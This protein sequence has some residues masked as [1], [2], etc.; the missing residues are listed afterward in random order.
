MTEQ[1]DIVERL[2]YYSATGNNPSNWPDDMRSAAD[3]I[4]RLENEHVLLAAEIARLREQNAELL[5]ALK[6]AE[7]LYQ[8]GL[9]F[10]SAEEIKQVHEL[11][12]AAIAAAEDRHD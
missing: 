6:A 8:D 5:A 10:T 2:R 7:R 3:E 11:R 12:R 1:K 4:E 9:L